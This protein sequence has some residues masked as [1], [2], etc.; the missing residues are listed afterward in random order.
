MTNAFHTSSIRFPSR[1]RYW[2]GGK[3]NLNAAPGLSMIGPHWHPSDLTL[4]VLW[5]QAMIRENGEW[6]VYGPGRRVRIPANLCHQVIF[7][8]NGCLYAT[9]QARI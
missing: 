9:N 1:L 6:H 5:G 2:P 4:Y 3:V 8:P 7:G